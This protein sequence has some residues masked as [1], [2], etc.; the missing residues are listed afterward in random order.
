MTALYPR[1]GSPNPF[2]NVLP[3]VLQIQLQRAKGKPVQLFKMR[4]KVG[5]GFCS[6][7]A[8]ALESE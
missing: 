1:I 2:L 4:R 6:T 5:K 7:A 3:S 8:N